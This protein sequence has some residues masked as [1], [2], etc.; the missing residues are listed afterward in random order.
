[1]ALA[2]GLAA[3]ALYLAQ[4]LLHRLSTE[5]GLSSAQISW[6]VTSTQVGYAAGLILVV[7]L[8]DVVRRARLAMTLLLATAVA[9]VT[10]TAAQTGLVLIGAS[11]ATSVA[12]VGAQVLVPMAA[13]LA[14]KGQSGRVVGIVMA[15][16][17]TGGLVVR[18]ASG[19]LA[20]LFGW[21][22]GYWMIA[23]LLLLTV[24]ILRP[25]LPG[26][27][28]KPAPLTI[29]RYVALLRSLIDPIRELPAFRRRT[30]V[31]ALAMSAFTIHLAVITLRLSE[32][33][34]EWNT[35]GIG[36]FSL[37]AAVGIPLMPLAGRLADAGHARFL[38]NSGLA[39]ELAAWLLMLATG[40]TFLG[41]AVGVVAL[42][43]G[44][45]AVMAA[46]QSIV[47]DL[48][49][50]ARSRINS[51]FMALCFFGGAAGTALAGSL[52]SVAG[53]VGACIVAIAFV[54]IGLVVQLPTR[55]S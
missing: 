10:V 11:V 38:I 29:A 14:P 6:L 4:P 39:L 41:L 34:F 37:L 3:S 8:G 18:A 50:E 24:L 47:Y 36:A 7:P 20:D 42:V 43:C 54:V 35:T 22:S 33:P 21:R 53:W 48:R 31:A 27:F 44:Q 25:Q 9:L 55:G 26:N 12:A 32:S 52:W 28:E 13:A 15:G 51:I 30:L 2:A 5:Y 23:G 1:M 19:L 45:Q 40:S 46:T 49:P 16:V 17:L